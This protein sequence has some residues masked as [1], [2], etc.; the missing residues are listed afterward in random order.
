MLRVIDFKEIDHRVWSECLTRINNS[1]QTDLLYRNYK[2]LNPN[3]YYHFS[4]IL[5]DNRIIAFGGIETNPNKWGNK[6]ARVLTRF[7][8]DPEY[9]T[10]SFTKWQSNNIRYSPLILKHQ[11]DVLSNSSI[12][13]AM[14]TREG[15]YKNSFIKIVELANTVSPSLFCIQEGKYNV[16]EKLD[17]VPESCKQLIA[18]SELK[19]TNFDEYLNSINNYGLLKKI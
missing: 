1:C 17:V 9:R 7:W 14:I 8:I 2:N 16:C 18:I 6:L 3:N 4:V 11:L 5:E 12:E 10:K 15:N 19:N 13:F